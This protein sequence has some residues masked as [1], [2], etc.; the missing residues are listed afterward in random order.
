VCGP[1]L[2]PALEI[3]FATS[4][5]FNEAMRVLDRAPDREVNG[6]RS[7]SRFVGNY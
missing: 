5:Y 2:L 4:A 1:T 3:M 7:C 6:R